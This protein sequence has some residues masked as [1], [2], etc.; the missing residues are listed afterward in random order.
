VADQAFEQWRGSPVSLASTWADT[1]ADVQEQLPTLAEE[2]AGWQGDLDI[3]VGGTVLDS[4]ES[5]AE[6]AKGAY[7]DRWTAM[8]KNLQ[9]YRGSSPGVTYVRPFH[10]FNGDWYRNWFVT[11]DNVE[12]YKKSFRLMA[13]V[14]RENCPSCLIAWSPNNGSSTGAAPLEAAY[15][16]DDVVDVIS[17]DSYNANG[18][19]IVDSPAAWQEYAHARHGSE[20]VGVETWRQF[21]EQRGKPMALPEWGLNPE[22]GGGDNPEYIRGMNDWLTEHA[23]RPGEPNLAGKILYEAYFNVRHGGKDG[24]L[25]KDGPNP[26][27]A[28]VYQSL[29]WGTQAHG[30]PGAAVPTPPLDELLVRPTQTATSQAFTVAA[31][32]LPATA[33]NPGVTPVPATVP[34]PATPSAASA[35]SPVHSSAS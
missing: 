6:A 14:I 11:P 8:A 26:R 12:D 16:G 32:P 5:Y 27:S 4:N 2:Y 3:A 23:A 29:H 22:Y 21:A 20:P 9:R 19:T 33:P 15:P 13:S 7:R 18:N 1:S 24:Y 10:E 34:G 28:Q 31:P 17:V 35:P 25:I 30:T